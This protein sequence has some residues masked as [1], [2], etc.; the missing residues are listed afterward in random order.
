MA[1]GD[2]Q[3][4]LNLTF[5]GK[6][7]AYLGLPFFIVYNGE[8]SAFVNADGVGFVSSFVARRVELV[9]LRPNQHVV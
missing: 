8:L 4:P 5:C 1:S 2:L 9:E 6:K 3:V 7:P